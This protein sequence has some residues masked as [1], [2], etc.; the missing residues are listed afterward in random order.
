MANKQK[1]SYKW[2]KEWLQ[3]GVLKRS[4]KEKSGDWYPQVHKGKSYAGA[5]FHILE[6]EK[7]TWLTESQDVS[8]K[9]QKARCFLTWPGE[10]DQW[11]QGA[12]LCS[13]VSRL[14]ALL[15]ELEETEAAGRVTTAIRNLHL[16]E[17]IKRRVPKGDG[18]MSH[19]TLVHSWGCGQCAFPCCAP[20]ACPSVAQIWHL[21]YSGLDCSLFP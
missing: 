18:R 11:S 10:D 3:K 7:N 12:H 8:R 14:E 1:H 16:E 5:Y 6:K 13:L 21:G 9:T 19:S 15:V 20:A 2:S 17:P 4:R